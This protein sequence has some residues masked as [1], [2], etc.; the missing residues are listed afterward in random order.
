[1]LSFVIAERAYKVA[2]TVGLIAYN[3]VKAVTGLIEG[4]LQFVVKDA[5][6][7]KRKALLGG[8]KKKFKLLEQILASQQ[9]RAYEQDES[10]PYNDTILIEA[11]TAPV[12]QIGID[13]ETGMSVF[14]PDIEPKK[15]K[16]RKRKKRAEEPEII[17][18]QDLL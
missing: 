18:G 9:I 12:K 11:E 8:K 17:N 6:T 14:S 10:D 15:R 2:C 7:R 16:R 4:G 5:E 13:S 3:I 1:M